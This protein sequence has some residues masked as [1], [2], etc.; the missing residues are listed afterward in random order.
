MEREFNNS[1]DINT[2]RN[3]LSKISFGETG[4][5]Y[6]HEYES[7][8]SSFSVLYIPEWLS[9]GDYFDGDDYYMKENFI[10]FY[11]CGNL[12]DEFVNVC[13]DYK[14]NPLNMKIVTIWEHDGQAD[15]ET[16]IDYE[17]HS[18]TK[19]V[20]LILEDFK[21]FKEENENERWKTK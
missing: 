4:C 16:V 14:K 21:N 8:V 5:I 9:I 17:K 19:V 11:D 20:N 1:I 7:G 2:L 13:I 15:F 3:S 10:N 6:H 12:P 18:E